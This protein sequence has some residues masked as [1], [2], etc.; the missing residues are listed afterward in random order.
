MPEACWGNWRK[1]ASDFRVG[2]IV[3]WRVGLSYG[4][5]VA[6]YRWDQ[7]D[8]AG[9]SLS[10]RSLTRTVMG[11][12]ELPTIFA[13]SRVE[14]RH[15]SPEVLTAG[16]SRRSQIDSR[17]LPQEHQEHPSARLA[18]SRTARVKV[19]RSSLRRSISRAGLPPHLKVNASLR[20]QI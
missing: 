4:F 14:Q 16:K 9:R 17:A 1:P 2:R 6:E 12:R 15:T 3:G 19:L 8:L 11:S 18:R 10:D 20:P 5:N 13:Y 7:A